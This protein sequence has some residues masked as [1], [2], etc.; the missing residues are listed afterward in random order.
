MANEMAVVKKREIE[1]LDKLNNPTPQPVWDYDTLRRMLCWKHTIIDVENKEAIAKAK[2]MG[3]KIFYLDE[4]NRDQFHAGCLYFSGDSRFEALGDNFSLNKGVM[5]YGDFGCGKTALMEIFQMNPYRPFKISHCHDIADEY[6]KH[7][8]DAIDKF[9]GMQ[10]A[11][12]QLTF[13]HKET[14]RC[15]DE[16]GV[17]E[18]KKNF[19][20]KSNVIQEILLKVYRN[21]LFHLWHATTN[22]T[23]SDMIDFYGGKVG[24]RSYEMFNVIKFSPDAPDRRRFL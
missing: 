20:N 12:P 8:S 16:L 14:G 1:Y 11:Y 5:Y 4:W 13:G 3:K 9:A 22:L 21:K 7:G 15:L 19:G 17:E 18:E 24:S 23:R 6:A 2:D 10:P